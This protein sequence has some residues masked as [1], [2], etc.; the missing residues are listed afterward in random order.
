M[1]DRLQKTISFLFFL[2]LVFL[3]EGLGHIMTKSS[4][5]DWYLTL[6]KPE[7]TPPGWV[8]G[9]VWTL[10]YVMIGVAG[11][12]VY[13]K[14]PRSWLKI[15]GLTI[16]FLQLLANLLWT[17]FFFFLKNPFLAFID[18]LVLLGLIF[19][20]ILSFGLLKS[21]ASILFIPY[22]LWTCYAAILNGMIYFYNS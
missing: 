12:L 10:L 17:F 4:L 15:V 19:G 14:V 2:L 11:W 20:S 5:T 22:F 13:E 8:F 21:R 6:K 1:N 18:I 7:I 16:Y 9:P 3:V